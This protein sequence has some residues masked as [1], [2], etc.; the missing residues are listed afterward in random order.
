MCMVDVSAHNRTVHSF[1]ASPAL[2]IRMVITAS[3][4]TKPI[5]AAQPRA[6]LQNPKNTR[7]ADLLYG[8]LHLEVRT[9]Q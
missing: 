6:G 5:T 8:L 4:V 1:A 3:P 9:V 2:F 7:V